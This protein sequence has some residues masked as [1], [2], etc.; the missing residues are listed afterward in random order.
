MTI[1]KCFSNTSSKRFFKRIIIYNRLPDVK[2]NSFVSFQKGF[3]QNNF[4]LKYMEISIEIK[5]GMF[6]VYV[7]LT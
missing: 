4:K 2:E 5:P 3:G 1:V 7:I 6:A